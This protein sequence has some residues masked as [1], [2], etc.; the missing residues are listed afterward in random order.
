MSVKR[1]SADRSPSRRPV[2][3]VHW[4]EQDVSDPPPRMANAGG[5]SAL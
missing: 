1:L 3:H 2:P 5:A 4:S